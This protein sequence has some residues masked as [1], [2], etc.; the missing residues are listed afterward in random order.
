[1]QKWV[2]LQA[3]LFFVLFLKKITD[4]IFDLID[5]DDAGPDLSGTITCRAFFQRFDVHLGANPLTGDLH[6]PELAWRKD[7]MFGAISRHLFLKLLEEFPSV[8]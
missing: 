2:Y 8:F 4:I 7:A 3:D 6:K 5:D 1:M